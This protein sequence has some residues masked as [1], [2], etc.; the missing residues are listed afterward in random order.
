MVQFSKA[1]FLMTKE[2]TKEK[3]FL[4][5]EKSLIACRNKQDEYV[6]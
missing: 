5:M 2:P 6:I 1:N 3:S 4:P